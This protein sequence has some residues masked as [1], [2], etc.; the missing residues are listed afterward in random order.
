MLQNLVDTRKMAA[1]PVG[2]VRD[3]AALEAQLRQAISGE[4]RFDAGSRALYAADASNYR[5]VPIGVVIPR[6]V[7]DVIETVRICYRHGAPVLSRGGGTSLCGQCCNVAVVMDFTKYMNNVLEI[8]TEAKTARVQPGTVLDDLRDAAGKHG[9]TFA[10]DPAT[11]THNTLGG[12]IGN[13][14]CGPHSVMGGETVH[15]IVE[16]DVLTYDGVRMTV[17]ATSEEDLRTLGAGTGRRAEIYRDLLALRDRYADE[18]RGRF[19]HIPRRVSGYNLEA[20]LPE[21]GFNVGRA[22]V[23]SEGTCV[24]V[25]EAKVRLLDNPPARSLLVLGYRDVYEAGD[26]VPEIMQHK[27]I[28]LE[29]M[30]DR[31]IDDMKAVHLHP[32]DVNL[33]PPGGGWLLVEFGGRDKK[34]S[35]DQARRAMETLKKVDHPPSMKLY[36]DPPVET[37]LWKVRESGLGA[38]AH[39]PNKPIT[40]EGW[41]DSAVP[42]EKLGEYLRKLRALFDKYGYGCDLYGHFGQG[43]VHTRIDFELET[44]EGIK[45]FRAFL[46]EAA[47]LVVSLGGTISGEHGDGQSKAELLPIMFGDELMRAFREF[48]QIWDPL[49]R[50]NP[51]KVV[52]AYRPD[53]N[54]RLGTE[55][56]PPE[57]PVHFHY[58]SDEG[59]FPRTLL[60][61]VGV[62]E[63][64]KKHGTMCPSYMA[65]GEEMH[66]TR[67][68]A[69][70]LF[71]MVKGEVVR[72]GWKDESVH[73]ALDLCLSCKGCK[74]ECPVNVDMATY[75]A[76][77]MS[78]YYDGRLRPFNAYAFGMI[79]RWARM[80]SHMPGFANFLTQKPPFSTLAKKLAHIAPQRRITP[81]AAQ[82]F[83]AWFRKR[84]SAQPGGTR[85]LLWPDT[86]NNYFHPEVAKDAV[87]VLEHAGFRVSIPQVHLCCGRPLYEFGMLDH[88]KHYLQHVMDALG[89]DIRNGTPIVGLE[90]A[91]VSVF[92]DELPNLFPHDEQ[93][94]R[95]QAQV[96][97]LSEFLDKQAGDFRFPPIAQRAI[98][99]GHCHHKSVLKMDAEES[100]LR[101]LGLDFRML[102]SGCC[103][104]AG[105]FGF[106]ADKYEVSMRCAERV[107]LPAVRAAVPDEL[108]IADGFSCRE[109]ILQTTSAQPLHLAQVLKRAIDQHP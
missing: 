29:G 84:P 88:A 54:L 20:L 78:H 37:L 99:H 61:C 67:G 107:L 50:M 101:K 65:T 108:V 6:S 39:V 52:D 51:G 26:H 3:V 73:E 19:P 106:E 76:E 41:E 59:S 18:I 4:V 49:N 1:P 15:N 63:C 47:E 28:A 82:S 72:G 40:W 48:K 58:P 44:A 81:F 34:D 103:G 97:M 45:T 70:L 85:I 21:H 93:A 69:H 64:R 68:R 79:D 105:S 89:D 100:V 60:R 30:D 24:V 46:H 53:Q 7:E 86:F 71:E 42:P 95:L 55:Y 31:L 43:C 57:L 32:Q 38:T 62:G 36:D 8:D 66:S 17:G 56:S 102:D 5:Q 104:M 94:K 92:R 74:G 87:R 77:F 27:P 98:V 96:F 75:K 23:G 35:D 83:G 80:A 13:N 2:G 91:C 25:L 16:L 14:S 12:M 109:Q 33:L 10:P 11:H 22:L 9:L 90:P